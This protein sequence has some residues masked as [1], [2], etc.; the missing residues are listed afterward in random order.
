[1]LMS[2]STFLSFS[3][4]SQRIYVDWDA[5]EAG[6]GDVFFEFNLVTGELRRNPDIGDRRDSEYNWTFD[7]RSFVRR[8][9][10][11]EARPILASGSNLRW[12]PRSTQI[13]FEAFEGT[14]PAECNERDIWSIS[15]LLNGAAS[16]RLARLPVGFRSTG[17]G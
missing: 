4:D 16:L 9:D 6:T 13:T 14:S 17:Q 11:R 2:N 15:S 12:S 8:L 7:G 1:M 10:G 3:G 5:D